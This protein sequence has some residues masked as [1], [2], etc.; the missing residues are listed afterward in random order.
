MSLLN[1]QLITQTDR[2]TRITNAIAIPLLVVLLFTS[3]SS[4]SQ[5]RLEVTLTD[6]WKFFKG[7]QDEAFQTTYDDSKWE[8]VTI[9][10]D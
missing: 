5:N 1:R 7:K 9:P 8:T 6:N 4:Y 2:M 10:H 3:L